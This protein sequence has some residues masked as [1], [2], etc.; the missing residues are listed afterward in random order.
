M[1][2]LV[3]ETLEARRRIKQYV[4]KTPLMFSDPLSNLTS[5]CKVF[6]K[7]ENEQLTGSFK[8]R[9]AFNKLMKLSSAGDVIKQKGIITASSGNHGMACV[10]AGKTL[11]IPVTV[12]CQQNVS[13]HKKNVLLN[14]GVRVVLHG[15]DC[16]EAENEGRASAEKQ[17]VEYVSPYNDIYVI[18]GQGTIGIEILE[19]CPEV[20]CVLVP[21]GGG[22]LIGGIAR[23]IKQVRPSVEIIG[24]QPQNSKVMYE[25]VR[26][27]RVVFEESLDTLSEGTA[28]GLEDNS[29]TLPICAQYVDDWIMVTEEE[30]GRAVVYMLQNHQKVVEGAAGTA[31]GAY[32][33]N[34]GRFKGKRVVL[35]AC[36]GNLGIQTLKQLVSMYT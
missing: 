1:D 7:L 11:G 35:I 14:K 22:G 4:Y 19:D 5:S 2:G 13:E 24:C 23:Y 12:Y 3:Q 20:D 25:S 26:A 30:I 15:V 33:K 36:G 29:I 32:L 16:V 8:I 10:E 28:G 9:G 6:I 31:L 34:P 18:A 27:G 21:V 17:E